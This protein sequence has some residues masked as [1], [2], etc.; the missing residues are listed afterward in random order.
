MQNQ[1]VSS[2][3]PGHPDPSATLALVTD[4]ST[5]AMGAVLQ[6]QLQGGWH[7]LAFFSRKLSPAQQKYRA[8]DRELLAIYDA[9]KY[10]RHSNTRG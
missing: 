2:R 10:F 3:S 5:T 1:F 4:V 6:Q 8:Y 9:V 7:P